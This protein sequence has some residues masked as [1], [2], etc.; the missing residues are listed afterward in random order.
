[1]LSPEGPQLLTRWTSQKARGVYN[2][3]GPGASVHPIR[4]L[5]LAIHPFSRGGRVGA[6]NGAP[7]STTMAEPLDIGRP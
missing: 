4:V 3:R 5:T 1:M 2:C 6:E 7:P